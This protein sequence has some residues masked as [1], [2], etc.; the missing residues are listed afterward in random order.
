MTSGNC[1][2]DGADISTRATGKK[3]LWMAVRF[4]GPVLIGGLFVLLAAFSWRKWP[5][6]FVDFG[7]QLYIPWR[8]DEGAVLYRDLFYMSGGPLVR[9]IYDPPLAN[10]IPS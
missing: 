1:A 2:A 4:A 8:I 3:A 7:V 10:D 5:D 9:D 6:F